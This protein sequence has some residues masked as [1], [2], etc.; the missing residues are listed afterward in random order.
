MELIP[1]VA[2]WLESGEGPVP[3]LLPLFVGLGD[4]IYSRADQRLSTAPSSE[5]QDW[6]CRGCPAVRPKSK[7]APWRGRSILLR[8]PDATREE[9][10]PSYH[11][12]LDGTFVL[13]DH[14][15]DPERDAIENENE[16]VARRVLSSI[17]KRDRELLIR[18]YLDEQRP[19]VICRDMGL[20]EIEIPSHQIAR[21]GSLRRVG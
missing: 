6:R 20:P 1:G 8:G 12:D 14:H 3:Q 21:Q 11:A 19:E 13:A 15:P 9:V 2:Y 4:A 17:R 10:G 16:L 18:F 5:R 7:R